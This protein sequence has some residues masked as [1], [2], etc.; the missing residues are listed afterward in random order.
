MQT[1]TVLN[2]YLMSVETCRF[3]RP[4]IRQGVRSSA[5]PAYAR[6]FSAYSRLSAKDRVTTKTQ[7]P[8]PN[9]DYEKR[10]AQLQTYTDL[11]ACYPRLSKVDQGATVSTRSLKQKSEALESGSTDSSQT[12]TISGIP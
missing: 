9:A 10:V 5:N 2:Q 6:F 7:T 1:L 8:S 3:L 12:L 11:N 4:L